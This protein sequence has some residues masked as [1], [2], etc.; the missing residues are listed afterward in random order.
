MNQICS[1]MSYDYLDFDVALNTSVF[2]RSAGWR[3]RE[4]HVTRKTRLLVILRG[5]PA[6]SLRH[7]EG[8]V[9]IFDYEKGLSVDWRAR[10]PKAK[11]ISLISLTKP[12]KTEGI[13]YV[14]GYLPVATL[15]GDMTP[16]G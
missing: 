12:E 8:V 1:I 9:H 5:D 14:Y 7:Y 13:N 16:R 11:S 15:F 10:L 2:Y 3:I 4:G 6:D